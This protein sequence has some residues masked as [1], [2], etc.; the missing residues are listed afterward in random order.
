MNNQVLFT[1]AAFSTGTTVITVIV[2]EATVRFLTAIRPDPPCKIW[3][4]GGRRDNVGSD[5]EG[6]QKQEKGGIG[7]ER[8]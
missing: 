6:G 8:S 5:A 2:D 7:I 4:E 1:L 3:R